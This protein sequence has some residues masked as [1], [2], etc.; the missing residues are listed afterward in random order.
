MGGPVLYELKLKLVSQDRALPVLPPGYCLLQE[1][2]K[3]ARIL[4]PPTG[5]CP[6]GVRIRRLGE[7]RVL[8]SKGRC[9][10]L[11]PEHIGHLQS[12]TTEL[13]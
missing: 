2:G 5:D 4:T 3:P 1:E 7:L 6:K 9:L 8:H 10:E 13:W 11:K 12:G